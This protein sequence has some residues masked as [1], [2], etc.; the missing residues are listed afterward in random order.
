MCASGLSHR[1]T[2]IETVTVNGDEAETVRPK[3]NPRDGGFV[4]VM[5]L[6]KSQLLQRL[7]ALVAKEHLWTPESVL[8]SGVGTY[9]H[10]AIASTLPE[11]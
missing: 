6:P 11:M 5:S 3:P 10:E 7:D 9:K 2:H 8:C 4:K 1:T